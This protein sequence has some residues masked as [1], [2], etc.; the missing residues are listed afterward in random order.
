MAYTSLQF[1]LLV[2]T[3]SPVR[4][5]YRESGSGAPLIFLHGGWGYEIYPFASQV[6][7]LNSDHHCIMPD[8]SGYGRSD[9][10]INE[11]PADFHY[12]AATETLSLMDALGIESASFWGH[13][14]GA[15]I[16]AILG[17]TAPERVRR[18][19]LEAFHYYGQKARSR[20]FFEVLAHQP[21][22]LGV[23][24]CEQFAQEHGK[25]YWRQLITTHAHAWLELGARSR[26]P[27]DDLY[28]GRLREIT[29]PLL[30]VHGRLDPR[31]E[32]SEKDEVIVQLPHGEV[33]ILDQ[34]M[35]SPHSESVTVDDVTAIAREFL[36]KQ[37]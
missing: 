1:S 8:R 2:P 13:S 29:S 15:V 32:T 23:E 34:G 16:A 21:E 18:I 35:H 3:V 33:H 6:A 37:R 4:I 22:M 5:F 19:I 10:L 36:S 11:L 17:F 9:H 14:D 24:L 7:A 28:G 27:R 20:N 26:G 12:H 25:D 31:T 30:I